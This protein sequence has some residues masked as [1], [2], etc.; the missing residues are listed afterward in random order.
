M[1]KVCAIAVCDWCGSEDPSWIVSTN[2]YTSPEISLPSGWLRVSKN[3]WIR[4]SMVIHFINDL[5]C[6]EKCK[7]SHNNN[8]KLKELLR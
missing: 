7:T 4:N 5:F 2:T 3:E 8:K 6:S 1:I